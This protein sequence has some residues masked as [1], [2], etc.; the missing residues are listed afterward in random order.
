MET[1]TPSTG[2]VSTRGGDGGHRRIEDRGREW[3]RC[4]ACDEPVQEG[5]CGPCAIA[6]PGRRDARNDGPVDWPFQGW[7]VALAFAAMAALEAAAM[8]LL[9]LALEASERRHAVSEWRE[10]PAGDTFSP[11]PE[12]RVEACEEELHLEA[13]LFPGPEDKPRRL[14]DGPEGRR[15]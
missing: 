5:C 8:P 2:E 4:S 7:G 14:A 13:S 12:W 11:L 9:S 10:D 6:L 3:Q 1:K 15:R